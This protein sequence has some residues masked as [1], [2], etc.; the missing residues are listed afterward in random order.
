MK[1]LADQLGLLAFFLMASVSFAPRLGIVSF[2][3]PGPADATTLGVEL[4]P[5]HLGLSVGA[6][7]AVTHLP[8]RRDSRGS[9][10][11]RWLG[12]ALRVFQ[13]F[14]PTSAAFTVDDD[15]TV[16]DLIRVGDA[17]LGAGL[18]IRLRSEDD[19]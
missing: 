3:P 5:D 14:V 12:D 11:R 16:D 17:C 1:A 9:I 10:D 7:G 8:L 2:G 19:R 4:T 13:Q 6:D 18:R 15:V